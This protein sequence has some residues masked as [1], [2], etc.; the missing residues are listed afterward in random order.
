VLRGEGRHGRAGGPRRPPDP[1]PGPVRRAS[2]LRR[3]FQRRARLACLCL[4]RRARIAA[5]SY[6]PDYDRPPLLAAYGAQRGFRFDARNRFFRTDGP[7]EPLRARFDL[8]VGYGPS[9]VNRHRL[10]LFVLDAH[11][12]VAASFTRRLWA[13]QEVAEA[14]AALVCAQQERPAS[15]S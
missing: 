14:V 11:G 12:A 15:S 6:D 1:P 4:A 2:R 5:I 9:T 7:V 10:E 8:G 13:E 3:F